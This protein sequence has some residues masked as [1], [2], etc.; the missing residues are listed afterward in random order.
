[1]KIDFLQ[2]YQALLL[3]LNKVLEE[4]LSEKETAELCFRC[5]VAHWNALGDRVKKEGF[6]SDAEEIHF[7]RNTKHFF[8]GQIE[9]FIQRYHALQFLP[10][11]AEGRREFWEGEMARVD[12]FFDTYRDFFSYYHSRRTDLDER[13]FLLRNS[14][15]SNLAH[16]A[17]Y[18]LDQETATSHDWL[19]TNMVAYEKYK[20]YVEG[21][22]RKG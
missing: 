14:D 17:V 11:S 15:G 18:D 8:T 21:E 1:M 6:G 13:Y 5:C 10:S 3:D 16:A 2:L 7:F 20:R 4:K 22:L 12:K 9:Y 19:L